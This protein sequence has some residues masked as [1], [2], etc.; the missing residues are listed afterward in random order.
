MKSINTSKVRIA[1]ATSVLGAVFLLAYFGVLKGLFDTW[2]NNEDYSYGFLI[3]LVA[4]YLIWEKKGQLKS[5]RVSSNWMGAPFFF[6]FLL[7]S[8]YGM[9]GSSPSAVRPAIP[10]M[11]LAIVLFCFGKS[12]LK[13]V[14]FPLFF[15]VFMIPLPTVV[16]TGIGVPLK[17]LST[18]LG[19]V[20]LHLFGVSVFV[21]GNVID[22]GVTQLQVVDACSGLRYIL[23]LLALGVLFAYFFEKTKWKQVAL[24][25]F[26]IP[27]SVITNGI[28]I[29]ATGIL[30]QKYGSGM[31]E[32]FFHDFSGWVV[33]MF[34]FA[35]LF[36]FM[37]LLKLFAKP[38]PEA[39][40]NR[41]SEEGLES[42]R[43]RTFS[44]I[45]IVICSCFLVAVAVAGYSVG[46]LPKIALKGGFSNFPM[47]IGQS[48]GEREP[49]DPEIIALSGAEEAFSA[50]FRSVRST[51]ISLY[52][53]YRGSPFGENNNFFHSP[54]I[55]L[56]SSGWTT[57]NMVKHTVQGVPR[58]GSIVVTEMVIEQLGRK[59]LVYYWFQ[60]KNR[61]S[62]DVNI[63]RFHLALH[64]LKR[65]NTYDIFIR[66]ITP[67][68]SNET[69]GDAEKRMD[70]F[71]RETLK[72]LLQ[73]LDRQD[74]G[75][76]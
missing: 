21:Q 41:I 43:T 16:Q 27:V 68:L 8:I 70:E 37:F 1:T 20:L 24:V 72:V 30:A 11:L 2:Y 17:L 28:R 9:L 15:L 58:F 51:D 73:F 63:N 55:C 18:K 34:A 5:I 36:G 10:F 60:T 76:L 42:V 35:L 46:A 61:S 49:I 19:A 33:F 67:L 4:A 3:P 6:F 31:A 50:V 69:V 12:A 25:I 39:P 44:L 26:T 64:A 38:A 56:P 57:L 74:V 47:T 66:P 48:V 29:G 52:I 65:D 14:W 62:H 23:P 45:P 32:G 53:G 13:A 7:V 71:A 75:A 54:N 40:E 22:L 59:Q